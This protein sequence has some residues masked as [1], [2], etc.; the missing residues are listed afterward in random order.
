MEI[1][2]NGQKALVTGAG[3]GIGRETAKMLSK[4]GA[5]TYA[6]SRTEEHL[7]TLVEEIVVKGMLA[8]KRHGSIVNISSQ[9][10]LIALK[11][12]GVYSSTKGA[13]DALTRSMALE[14][15]PHGIRV[16]CVNPTVVLTEMGIKFWTDPVRAG[17]MLD[18]IPLK[19]FAGLLKSF[20]VF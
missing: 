20:F 2:F 5:T 11:N 8:D 13:L 12:H 14:L 3:R 19:K 18:R 1:K 16:N 7:K 10:S 9:A 4:C 17:P 6:L 15:G